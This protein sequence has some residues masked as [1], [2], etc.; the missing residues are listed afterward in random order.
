MLLD[1]ILFHEKYYY[2]VSGDSCESRLLVLLEEIFFTKRL[3]NIYPSKRN[4]RSSIGVYLLI[5]LKI[6]LIGL[7]IITV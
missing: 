7:L 5:W 4:M 3:M 1:T 2:Q 6:H